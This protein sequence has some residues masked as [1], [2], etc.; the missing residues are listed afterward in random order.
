MSVRLWPETLYYSNSEWPIPDTG[1]LMLGAVCGPFTGYSIVQLDVE[2]AL[3]N[4]GRQVI[5]IILVDTDTD[6]VL[7]QWTVDSNDL[8]APAD[9]IE[10][11][12]DVPFAYIGQYL[13]VGI[14][15]LSGDSGTVVW[16]HYDDGESIYQRQA[17]IWGVTLPF[18]P[19]NPTPTNAATGK[20]LGTATLSWQVGTE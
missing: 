14:S 2:L 10:L 20:S 11:I 13:A 8:S 15:K 17:K 18:K 5:S 16:R 19:K 3:A 4:S 6:E 1:W 12:C 7:Q 9:W